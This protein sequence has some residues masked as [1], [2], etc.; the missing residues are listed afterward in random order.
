[1]AR[2]PVIALNGVASPPRKSEALYG[3]VLKFLLIQLVKADQS[4][5]T[6]LKGYRQVLVSPLTLS[7][8]P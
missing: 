4:Y 8:V 2:S 1:M 6:W 3:S 5:A 7:F